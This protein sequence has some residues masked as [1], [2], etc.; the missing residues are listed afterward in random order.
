MGLRGNP[1]FCKKRVPPHFAFFSYSSLC[2]L[3]LHKGAVAV[4]FVE[5]TVRIDEAVQCSGFGLGYESAWIAVVVGAR[6]GFS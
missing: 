1:A 2:S 3:T 4:G 5:H 6:V